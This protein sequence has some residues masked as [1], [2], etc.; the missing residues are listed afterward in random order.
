MRNFMKLLLKN[1]TLVDPQTNKNDVQDVLIEGNRIKEIGKNISD[2]DAKVINLK[3]MVLTPGLVDVHVHFREPGQEY[4]ETIES[5]SKAAAAG[6]FTTVIME[7]NTSP[8]IDGPSKIAEVLKIAKKSGIINVYTKACITKGSLGKTLVDVKA[9][10]DAGAVAISDDGHPVGEEELMYEALKESTVASI[11]VSPHCEESGLYRYHQNLKQKKHP[12]L[13]GDALQRPFWAE[14]DFIKR[15]IELA[16]KTGA[17]L[18]VSHVS[19]AKS[20][21]LIAKAKMEG[22]NI[23]AEVTA[24]HLILTENDAK[25]IGTNAKA[26]PPLRTKKDIEGMREGLIKGTIDIIAS[27]HAP[28]SIQEKSLPWEAPSEQNEAPFGLIGLET[29]LAL[30]LTHFVKP[31]LLTMSQAIFKMSTLPAKIFGLEAGNM[32]LGS[33]ADITVIDPEKRWEIDVSRFYSKGRNCPFEGWEVQ[34]KAVM[35]IVGGRIVMKEGEILT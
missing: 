14:A 1:G 3:G 20:V 21:G 24:H 30:M 34:G 13:F 19:M 28:H 25:K 23:S 4:K 32:A 33:K 5:G 16:K 35:T 12:V 10:K 15:D 11:P 18:H 29:T 26:N 22:V 6:G 2:E 31:G 8:P 7:P 27:D 17:K 9:V